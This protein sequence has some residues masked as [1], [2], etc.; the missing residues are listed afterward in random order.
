METKQF[1]G[2]CTTPS[3]K[4]SASPWDVVHTC[5]ALSYAAL[6]Q[7]ALSQRTA[8]TGPVLPE[9][10]FCLT[11]LRKHSAAGN[12][13]SARTR[14]ST[15][16]QAKGRER[17]GVSED[18]SYVRGAEETKVGSILWRVEN[19]Q[20]VPLSGFQRWKLMTL[21]ETEDSMDK[22]LNTWIRTTGSKRLVGRTWLKCKIGRLSSGAPLGHWV[23]KK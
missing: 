21:W 18:F 12:F 2:C 9:Q 8:Q 1:S 10:S 17:A 11:D 6:A 22:S 5:S 19:H 3:C 16:C 20:I 14:G 4:T 13:E 23:S 15:E 7:S